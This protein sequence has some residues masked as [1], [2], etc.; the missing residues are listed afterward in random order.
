MDDGLTVEVN[1]DGISVK[2]DNAVR[3]IKLSNGYE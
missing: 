3:T 1:A 2:D